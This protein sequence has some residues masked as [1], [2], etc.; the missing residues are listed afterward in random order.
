MT[1]GSDRFR[2]ELKYRRSETPFWFVKTDGSIVNGYSDFSDHLKGFMSER[3]AG[4][5]KDLSDDPRPC[6][7]RDVN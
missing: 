7:K 6:I 1:A 3:F 5:A 4:V 2:K